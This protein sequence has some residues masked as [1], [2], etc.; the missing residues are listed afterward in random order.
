LVI[1]ARL[2]GTLCLTLI[3]NW[4]VVSRTRL[5]EMLRPGRPL[6]PDL[7]RE[8]RTIIIASRTATPE[9]AAPESR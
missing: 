9:N 3:G 8:A 7:V 6:W 2:G 4:P 1:A 5:D